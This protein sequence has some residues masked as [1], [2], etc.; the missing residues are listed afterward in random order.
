MNEINV[1][2]LDVQKPNSEF[3]KKLLAIFLTL[4]FIGALSSCKS[5]KPCPAYS[6]GSSATSIRA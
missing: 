4:V 5:S 3:M 1:L 6:K 2:F